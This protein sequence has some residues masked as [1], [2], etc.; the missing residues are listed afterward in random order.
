[1]WVTPPRTVRLR[2][3]PSDRCDRIPGGAFSPL[4]PSA[5]SVPSRGEVEREPAAPAAAWSRCRF[6]AP[7]WCRPARC[8]RGLPCRSGRRRRRRPRR[9]RPAGGWAA[10]A[11]D[12]VVD[13]AVVVR[14]RRRGPRAPSAPDRKL[15]PGASGE[16]RSRAQQPARRRA[17]DQCELVLIPCASVYRC[18]VDRPRDRPLP[19]GRPQATR[20]PGRPQRITPPPNKALINVD[21]MP[22]AGRFQCCSD[23][24]VKLPST[25]AKMDLA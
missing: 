24:L 7:R 3:P 12:R 15:G 20:S 6:R 4:L 22:A 16:R 18:H 25:S 10:A 19:A 9:S 2:L 13:G 17:H 14:P 21:L 1:M 23:V 8:S 11:G 5:S